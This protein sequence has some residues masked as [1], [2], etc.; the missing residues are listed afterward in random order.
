M[1]KL[2]TMDAKKFLVSFL[3]IVNVLF[4]VVSVSAATSQLITIESVKVDGISES[5]NED[6]SVIAGEKASIEVIFEALENASDVRIKAELQ[7][8]KVD[9]EVEVFV[10]DVEE[11]KRYKKTLSLRV[12]YELK[13]EIS[14]D[15]SLDVKIWNGDFKTEFAEIVLRIQRPSYNV[16]VMSIGTSNTVD[17]GETFPVDI[18]LKNVGYNKLDD[19]YVTVTLSELNVEARAY[20]GDLVAIEDFDSNNKKDDTVR[21]RLFL[22]VPFE[23]NAGVYALEVE[24]SNDDLTIN[25]VKQIVVKNELPTS[26]IRSG[27]ELILVNPTNK[28]K[29]YKVLPESPA[30]VSENTVV[31]PASSSRTVT[32]NPN[33]AESFSVSVFSGENLVG[34]VEFTNVE[35]QVTSSV[36]V[37]TV[38]LAIVFVVLLV[39][40]IVLLTKKPEKEEEFSE[41][42]Y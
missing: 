40:L 38:I 23:A 14:D 28:L 30:S 6:I 17:A 10:G 1:E 35:S 15:L 31:V 25:E 9:S 41:S 7:G 19:L 37:L 22:E 34:S 8:T 32:V 5:W 36:V 12:P 16:G 2:Q 39:V 4:L 13:D 3:T 42:Y 11:G 26:V 33:S 18:V 20:F 29:V 24:V 27:N 21:G